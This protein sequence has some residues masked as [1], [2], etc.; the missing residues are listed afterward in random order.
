[1]LDAPGGAVYLVDGRIGYAECPAVPGVGRLLGLLTRAELE[2][3]ALLALYDAAYVLFDAAVQ[4]YFEPGVAHPLGTGRAL[5][6]REVCREIDRRKRVPVDG[7]PAPAPARPPRPAE[8]VAV[9]APEP[10]SGPLPQRV[11]RVPDGPVR[12]AYELPCSE[13]QLRRIIA[14]LAAL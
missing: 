4:V 6:L 1:V 9:R 3:L 14:G 5:E 11:G 12:P 13:E 7:W 2:T 8:P 10:F